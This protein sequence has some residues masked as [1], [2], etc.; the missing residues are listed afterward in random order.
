MY[1]EPQSIIWG[2]KKHMN[3]LQRIISWLTQQSIDQQTPFALEECILPL[4]D[5][6]NQMVLLHLGSD[7]HMLTRPALP[8]CPQALL[9]P[10]CHIHFLQFS[11]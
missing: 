9:H 1:P 8:A 7:Q 5:T 6:D 2:I 3:Y 11:E 4:D 10:G